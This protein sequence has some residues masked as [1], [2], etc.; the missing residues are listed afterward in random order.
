MI[1]RD[2]RSSASRRSVRA[3]SGEVQSKFIAI[4]HRRE[5][6]TT[7]FQQCDALF[8]RF[9]T[10]LELARFCQFAP[11]GKEWSIDSDTNVI[12]PWFIRLDRLVLIVA[13][14]SPS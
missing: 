14:K 6:Q 5:R 9:K 10:R 1:D 8:Q 4:G 11:F 7:A 13:S 2:T 12:P 3:A